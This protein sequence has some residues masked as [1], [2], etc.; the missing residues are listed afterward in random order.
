MAQWVNR[1]LSKPGSV[2]SVPVTHVEEVRENSHHTAIDLVPLTSRHSGMHTHTCIYRKRKSRL[3]IL[4]LGYI[5]KD[6]YMGWLL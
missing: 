4:L 5:F 2:S 3:Q 6:L 1:L